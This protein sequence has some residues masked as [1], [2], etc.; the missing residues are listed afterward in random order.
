MLR[1]YLA[2]A[3]GN[4]GRNWLY[5]GITILGLA[6]SFAA[7][8]LIGLF[9]RDE[10][11]F[12]R[13]FPDHERIY[14][15]ETEILAPGSKPWR[16][17]QTVSTVG[18]YARLD[19]PEAEHV[20]RALPTMLPVRRGA[21]ETLE[22]ILWSDPD[23][24]K[25]LRFPILAG[26]PDAALAAPDGIV[27]TQRI[28]RKYFG[29]DAPIGKT[30]SIGSSQALQG[31]PNTQPEALALLQGVHPMRVMAVLK[32]IPANSHL[33]AE[34]YAPGS[35]AHSFL[36]FQ[37]KVPS[38]FSVSTLTYMKLKPGITAQSVRQRL[39]SF[40]DQ[41]YPNRYMWFKLMPLAGLHFSSFQYG[42][43]ACPACCV[44]PATAQSTP[45]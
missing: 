41:R 6:V 14:R 30:L 39:K 24:F 2:A 35:A 43:A 12:D 16:L 32:D 4:L 18:Q 19:F 20:A 8:V 33:S 17:A 23:F 7:A 10:Y 31:P 21:V 38:P 22:L 29:E 25:V 3:L 37:D 45:A 11:S 27:I 44:R 15:I 40:A 26:N 42:S 9:L 1:N 28:A 34:I 5:A 36:A 13:F